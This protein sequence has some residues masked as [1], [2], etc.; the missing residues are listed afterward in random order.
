MDGWIWGGVLCRQLRESDHL[1]ELGIDGKIILNFL[2][3][4]GLD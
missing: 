4:N 3:R 1:G 2:R